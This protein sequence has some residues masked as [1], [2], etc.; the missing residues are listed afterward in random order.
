M[1]CDVE[2]YLHYK[3]LRHFYNKLWLSERLGYECG[4]AEIPPKRAGWYIVRPIMN[5]RGMGIGS[6]KLW[7]EAQDVFLMS[8]GEFW[9]EIFEGRHLSVTYIKSENG[10][11]AYSIKH[12]YEGFKNKEGQ[13]VQWE[14]TSDIVVAPEWIRNELWPQVDVFNAEFI[15]E[16]LIEIHLR[17]TPDPAVDSLFPVWEGDEIIVDKLEKIGYSYKHSYDNADGFLERPRLGFMVKQR[18]HD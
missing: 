3:N 4:P 12:C 14:K 15:G 8:P 11:Q 16:R 5:L 9:C 18:R 10:Y 6:K 2:A 1:N 17:D 13:F 7:I